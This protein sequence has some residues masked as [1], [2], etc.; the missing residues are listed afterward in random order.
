LRAG[1][2]PGR[3][4]STEDSAGIEVGPIALHVGLVAVERGVTVHDVL[5]EVEPRV[6]ERLSNPE[7]ARDWLAWGKARMDIKAML[8]L[9]GGQVRHPLG[10][11]LW[12]LPR[13]LTPNDSRVA[14]PPFS[15]HQ[16]VLLG[17]ERH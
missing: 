14:L 13:A 17:S 6:Q 8:I 16:E 15:S 2:H 1:E 5:A 7:L 4:G 3:Q 11:I 9:E 12:E 10:K